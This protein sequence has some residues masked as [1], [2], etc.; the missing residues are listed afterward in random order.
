MVM[1]MVMVMVMIMMDMMDM[2]LVM[3]NMWPQKISN[4]TAKGL[5]VDTRGI[6]SFLGSS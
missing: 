6:P 3:T 5:G 2:T 1:V 4:H